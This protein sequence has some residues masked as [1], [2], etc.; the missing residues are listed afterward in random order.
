MPRVVLERP[1]VHRRRLHAKGES[2]DVDSGQL[3]RL[4]SAGKVREN[5]PTAATDNNAESGDKVTQS[6]E[7]DSDEA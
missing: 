1:H 3:E 5:Q 7:G 4:R 2:I 6:R